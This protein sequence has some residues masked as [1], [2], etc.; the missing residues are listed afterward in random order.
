MIDVLRALKAP[1]MIPM[2]YFSSFTLERFM[3]RIRQD[4]DVEVAEVPS[5]VVSKSTLP[6]K[7]KL[8]VLPG[9]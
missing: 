4:W 3:S 2:H 1:L 8:L 7:P 5:V 9:R 6:A